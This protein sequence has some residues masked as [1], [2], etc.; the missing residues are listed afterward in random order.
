MMLRHPQSLVVRGDNL[1]LLPELGRL[2]VKADLIVGSPPYS[3]DIAY[4]QHNDRTSYE[5]YLAYVRSF[6]LAAQEVSHPQT[7]LCLNIPLDTNLGGKRPV[8]ADWLHLALL[9]GW[10][11][12]TSIVWNEGNLKS[13]TAWGSF[14]SPSAPYITAPVEMVL[15]LYR[16]A[17]KRTDQKGQTILR[18]DFLTWTL[19]LWSFSNTASTKRNGHPAAYDEE[20]PRRLVQFYTFPGDLVLD[21]WVGSGTTC[22]VAQSLGRQSIGMDVSTDYVYR[23]HR[24]LSGDPTW[25]QSRYSGMIDRSLPEGY[26]EY[27]GSV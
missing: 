10:Q 17:W 14:R 26:S 8:Y 20:L 23:S 15:V 21:P 1:I 24:R 2:G 7:R 27:V 25:A 6:L 16:E 18:E 4:D 22:V 19:G 5:E 11:Y 12:Q 13:R 9:T 3:L